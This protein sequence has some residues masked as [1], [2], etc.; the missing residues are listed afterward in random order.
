MP[1]P[2]PSLGPP[3]YIRAHFGEDKGPSII[4]ANVALTA[5]A[6]LAVVLRLW[7][8][9]VTRAAF[10][11]DDLMIIVSLVS[12]CPRDA[13]RLLLPWWSSLTNREL[14]VLTYGICVDWIICKSIHQ[15]SWPYAFVSLADHRRSGSLLLGQALLQGP[16]RESRHVRKGELRW[17]MCDAIGQ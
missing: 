9:S 5:M 4:G 11:A 10:M 13:Q 15:F 6:T 16:C 8:K 14:Q 3:D 1:P 2:P 7:A 12:G 17:T